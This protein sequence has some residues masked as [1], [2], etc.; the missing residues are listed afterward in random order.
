MA[1]KQ[2]V[3]AVVFLPDKASDAIAPLSK[4][5]VPSDLASVFSA[6]RKN[7]S[8][9]VNAS[10]VPLRL[11]NTS[12]S[13][14]HF[15]RF[16][17]AERIRRLN[18]EDR[19]TTQDDRV[20]SERARPKWA[21][22]AASPEG[23]TIL[24]QDVINELDSHLD[25]Q[26]FAI[27]NGELLRMGLAQAWTAVEILIA[28]TFRCRLKKEPTKG[29]KSALA[30][31]W[32]GSGSGED[33]LRSEGIWDLYQRRH[34][35]VHRKGIVDALYLVETGEKRPLGSV[36][37]IT[38]GDLEDAITRASTFGLALSAKL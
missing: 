19:D 25:D 13:E 26:N 6:F 14:R 21:A 15:Q 11:V 36:L 17:L 18:D 5:Q 29:I 27:A 32:V 22:F 30:D 31:I 34:L 2:R 16:F 24:A 3:L 28:D 37:E 4:I 20:A 35:I 1:N 9:V 7:L 10:G 12:V 23:Q 38:A 8:L 33:I